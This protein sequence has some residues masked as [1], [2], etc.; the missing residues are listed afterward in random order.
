MNLLPGFPIEE[1]GGL[2]V[3]FYILL[4][5]GFTGGGVIPVD[6]LL[7]AVNSSKSEL[8]AV[9]GVKIAEIKKGL[10]P[11]DTPTYTTSNATTVTLSPT[12]SGSVPSTGPSVASTGPTE[13]GEEANDDWKYIV[14]GVV[15]GVV[16]IVILAGVIYYV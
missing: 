14:V 15:V 2:R 8:E 10:E 6:A 1:N 3:A 12:S 16:I 13:I 4:P 5:S 11:T 7:Q 9:L